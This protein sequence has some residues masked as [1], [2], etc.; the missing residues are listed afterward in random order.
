MTNIDKDLERYQNSHLSANKVKDEKYWSA[1]HSQIEW[2]LEIA[3]RDVAQME[4]DQEECLRE[5]EKLK[6]ARGSCE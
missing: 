1:R 6:A 4:R 2:R 3:R 5:I